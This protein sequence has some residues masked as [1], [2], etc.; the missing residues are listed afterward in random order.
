MQTMNPILLL[1]YIGILVLSLFLYFRKNKEKST[2]ISIQDISFNKLYTVALPVLVIL[3]GCALR[4]YQLSAIPAGLHQDEASIGYEAFI[5][6]EFGM[7]RDGNRYPIYPIT[8]GSGGGSP[9][10]IYLNA[11]TSFLFGSNVLTLRALPA[12]L[13]CLTLVIIFLLVRE[14]S[15][16]S[17]SKKET[18]LSLQYL[19]GEFLWLPLVSLCVMA[20]S[21]WHIMLS[22]WSLDSNTTPFWV[23]T[24]MLLFV[25]A[26]KKQ[27]ESA[28]FESI[29]T[30]FKSADQKKK[31]TLSASAPDATILYCLSA[32]FYSLTLYSYGAATIVIP[33]HLVLMCIIFT[34]SRRMTS[35]QVII[36]IIVFAVFSAPLF[37]F[38]A[39]NFF[40][41]PQ[42]I[43]PFFSIT[44]FTAKRS[45][46]AQGSGM[47]LIIGHN[48]LTMLKN[49]TIGNSSEQILNYIP[50]FPPFYA[51][52]FPLSIAGFILSIIRTKKGRLIDLVINSFALPAFLFGLFVD[53]DIT[54]M[55][56]IFIPVIYYLARGFIFVVG[57]FVTVEKKY[58]HSPIRYAAIAAKAFTP[59]LFILA[60][61]FFSRTYFTDF[62]AM[63]SESYM[64]GY[65]EACVYAE[66][67]I[68]FEA[69]VYSTYEH[70]SA[71]FMV[72]LYYTKTPPKDFL[73]TVHYKDP[74]AEFRIADS[75]THF[76]FGLPKDIAEKGADY[77][78][79]GDVFILHKSQLYLFDSASDVSVRAFG[80]FVVVC[81]KDR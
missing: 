39:V 11:V 23:L 28:S 31:R 6:S 62:N 15:K 65:G 7:D 24:A 72:A 68:G 61:L 19:T 35:F 59:F 53:E 49:L 36:G 9:L 41:L 25:I 46:F 1:S 40:D 57:E 17:V 38:Y 4:L 3:I 66:E 34:G 20:F 12:I 22:R 13:G 78:N 47:L 43:T 56:L 81:N 27:K 50:G 33:I 51:F 80:D 44:K 55:V 30:L 37:I 77:L 5:L 52:T 42:I 45:V 32:F 71:P 74:D 79:N 73:L 18:K 8:Y 48:L 2:H 60:T 76:K 64:P 69:T 58:A 63:S 21:P 10:M 16:E 75:F 29:G 67:C 70:V 14:L 54:R 26:S